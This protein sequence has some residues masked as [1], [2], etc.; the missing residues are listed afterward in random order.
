L[1]LVGLL[2]WTLRMVLAGRLEWRRTALDLPMVLLI[3]LVLVQ[4]A[5]GNGPL[6]A[7]ALAPPEGAPVEPPNGLIWVGTVSPPQTHDALLVFLTYVGVYLLVVNLVRSRRQLESLVRTLVLVGGVLAFL[8]L[9]DYLGGE[10]RLLRWWDHAPVSRVSGTL[11]NPDHWASWLAMLICLGIGYVLARAGLGPGR[12]LQER[13]ASR[14]GREE[15]VRRYLPFASVGVMSLALVFTLSRGGIVSLLVAL[16]GLLAL[17]GA[18]GRARRSLVLV[19]ALLMVT[20]SYGAWIGL[21]PLAARIGE[22]AYANRWIQFVTTLPMLKTFPVL[23][24]GLGAYRD[25]YFRYQPA[26]LSPGTVY[27]A[28]A[29]NDLLQL[30]VE[31]GVVGAALCLWASWRVGG[32]LV[33]AHLLGRGRCPVGGGQDEGAARREAASVG[34]ALGAL[35]GVMSLVVHSLFDFGARIPTNG[36]LAAACLGIATAALHIR[37][38][39][40]G[41]ERLL[42]AVRVRD[43]GSGRLVP[44]VAGIAVVG[45]ALALVPV[46]V[47]P[48]LVEAKLQAAAGPAALQKVQEALAL[49]PHDVPSLRARGRLRLAAAREVWNSGRTPDGR[50]LLSWEERRREGLALLGGAV[51]DM[52]AALSS[53]PTDPYLHEAL[54]WAYGTEAVIDPATGSARLPSAF[55]SLRRAIALQPENPFLYRSLAALALAQR[56]PEM[57]VALEAARGATMR[58]PELLADLVRRFV[59][60]GATGDQWLRLVPPTPL[61]RLELAGLLERNGLP[62]EAVSVYRQAIALAPPD[63]EPLARW[64]LARLLVRR[65]DPKSAAAETDAALARDPDNPELHVTRARALAQLGEAAALEAHRVAIAKAETRAAEPAGDPFPFQARSSRARALVI[66]ALA[67]A[68]RGRAVKYH[69]ALAEYL[70]ERKLWGPA[71]SEWKLVLASAPQDAAAHFGSGLALSGLGERERAVEEHRTAVSL[72]GTSV[73]FRLGL[74]QALWD[75][76]QY[77]Q[78][79]NEW[80]A[81]LS[82]EPGHI[83]ARL[84]LARAYARIGERLDAARE[85]RRILQMVGEQPEAKRELARLG[86][87]LVR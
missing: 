1:T 50:I 58:E 28:F 17:Q 78:A 49:A 42:T 52:R 40:G 41:D 44:A 51:E 32:D 80:R 9:L 47:R 65:N 84:A 64:L 61:D 85:Y 14:Q 24:V 75:T 12:P 25:V 82:Q 8:G 16:L 3:A 68:E 73:V 33:G 26:E 66:E 56:Q 59:A 87:A 74:A 23:G 62:E 76:D 83:D 54:G 69:R 39:G 19:G 86:D 2:S 4:L 79:I 20:L 11:S 46:L 22:G 29:H 27:F 6:V 18:R 67:P 31:T 38:S 10:A 53:T 70:I 63:T 57:A 34:I 5:V 7:W 48:A 71:L 21:G 37:F 30:V 72:A 60:A 55:G 81:V 35:A 77:Y 15:L 45:G 36:I 43:L 13:L